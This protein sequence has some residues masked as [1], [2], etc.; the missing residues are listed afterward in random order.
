MKR[1]S[2]SEIWDDFTSQRAPYWNVVQSVNA[3]RWAVIFSPVS[4][5]PTK[6]NGTQN[7]TRCRKGIGERRHRKRIFH[8]ETV[9]EIPLLQKWIAFQGRL[10]GERAGDLLPLDIIAPIFTWMIP[11]LTSQGEESLDGPGHWNA[12]G[13]IHSSESLAKHLIVHAEFDDE[14]ERERPLKSEVSID[15]KF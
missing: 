7:D 15:E 10:W 6:Q 13:G 5:K 11:E 9:D 14:L 1:P 4:R 2:Q 8:L 3:R 12:V